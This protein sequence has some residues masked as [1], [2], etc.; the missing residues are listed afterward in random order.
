MGE[1]YEAWD[2]ELS[3]RVALKTVRP[4]LA[5][6]AVAMDRFRREIQLAR[7]VTH[8][9]VCR[10]F[11]LGRHEAGGRAVTFVTMEYL[12]G[13][14]LAARLRR[15]GR[16]S[17]EAALPL[18]EQM[19]AGLAAAHE[20]GIVH[21]DFKSPN[22]VLVP[23]ARG[24]RAVITDF[25]LARA[26]SGGDPLSATGTVMGT[27]DYMAPE[28][29]RGQPVGPATDLY[30]L[31]VVMYEM[32]TGRRPFEGDNPMAVAVQRLATR[33]TPPRDH[34][35][36]L[37]P[38][39]DA[40]IL[41]CLALEPV[42]RFAS[43]SDLVRALS[44]GPVS[45]AAARRLPI[46]LTA[47]A[48]VAAVLAGG[49]LVRRFGAPRADAVPSAPA[50]PAAVRPAVAVLGFKN[51]SGRAEASWLSTA[52]VEMLSTEMA[53]GEALRAV[54]T[55]DVS[56]ARSELGLPEAE[57]PG[58][59]RLARL[60]E[61]LGADYVVHG[62]YLVLPKDAGGQ[63]RLDARV[64]A[65]ATGEAVQSVTETADEKDVFGL[66]ARTGKRLRQ[67]LKADRAE[68][69]DAASALPRNTAA[70][71][72][73]LAALD[74][75]RVYDNPGAVVLLERAAEAD[76]TNALIQSRLAQTYW[77]RDLD[78][79]SK[80]VAQRAFD[81]S[82]DLP[83]EPRLLTEAL[84]W[85]VLNSE[86]KSGELYGTL[87]ALFP[88][89][90]EYG[91]ELARTQYRT[92]RLADARETLARLRAL[93]PP[94]SLDPRIDSMEANVANAEGDHRA[95]QAAAA[96]AAAG[97]LARGSRLH[98]AASKLLEARAWLALKDPARAGALAE[99][100]RDI[101]A[102]AGEH[103][104]LSRALVSMASARRA[105]GDEG[106]AEALHEEVLELGRRQESQTIQRRAL[107]ASADLRLA[108]S[109]LEGARV[110]LEEAKVISRAMGAPRYEARV[111]LDL[112][113]KVHQ[114][115]GKLDAAQQAAQEALALSR[116]DADEA[117]VAAAL[118]RIGTVRLARKDVAGARRSYEE[119]LAVATAAGL[120]GHAAEARTALD[121]LPRP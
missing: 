4:E 49:L 68:A 31:G 28:Q 98:V 77:Y 24:P 16:M 39:W 3:D 111:L 25:G 96:R 29:V 47:V 2:L 21:R 80:R 33:P 116:T 40:A 64:Q 14:T 106:G 92:D 55:E 7:K 34:V 105:Q 46:A 54:P 118:V 22:V 87:F 60:R 66:V 26:A 73:Y 18:V 9:N 50:T 82:R 83:R 32:V 20:A 119:A 69:S 6:D 113:G 75:L 42:D 99:E 84:Y 110:R 5:E 74:R 12:D 62:A 120:A 41:R 67:A 117:G 108:R 79:K 112:A 48:L 37:D 95:A 85:D 36:G 19:A 30:A 8:G 45:R 63:V 100:A 70:L 56:R 81:L 86:E 101:Y 51:L 102:D 76:P 44:D 93:P 27:P 59:E 109:D 72:L 10:T 104:G 94:A 43:A 78:A 121:R 97:S 71:R 52:L 65:V 17:T 88:D 13:E 35:P 115:Q 107:R 11:D 53:A 58:R 57:D 1:V 23:G 103:A 38:R 114:P 89:N 91:L 90:L 15:E 61:R